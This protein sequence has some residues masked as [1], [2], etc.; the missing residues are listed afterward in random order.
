MSCQ[1]CGRGFSYWKACTVC[2]NWGCENCTQARNSGIKHHECVGY[3]SDKSLGVCTSC[4]DIITRN[5]CSVCR[6]TVCLNCG[7]ERGR[8]SLKHPGCRGI[9]RSKCSTCNGQGKYQKCSYDE[10]FGYVDCH[11]CGATGYM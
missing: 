4:N 11:R 10:T 5:I 3:P 2:G 7:E 6:G 1:H 8:D 9:S